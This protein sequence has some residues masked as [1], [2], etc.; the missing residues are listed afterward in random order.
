MRRRRWWTTRSSCAATSICTP[1]P[2]IR[3]Q[4]PDV[5]GLKVRRFCGV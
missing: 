1:S 4:T 5:I 2:S 3:G